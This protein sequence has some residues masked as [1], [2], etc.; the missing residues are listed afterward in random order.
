[1]LPLE[2][3]ILLLSVQVELVQIQIALQVQVAGTQH[4]ALLHQQVVVGVALT[5]I[6]LLV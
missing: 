3:L 4:L 1:M 2:L 5:Q 6:L